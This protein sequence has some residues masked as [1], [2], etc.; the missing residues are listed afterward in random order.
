MSDCV[1]RAVA[2]Q[3]VDLIFYNT[4][5]HHHHPLVIKFVSIISAPS[6]SFSYVFV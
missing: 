5:Y 1:Y 4:H 2:W 3:R 6:H